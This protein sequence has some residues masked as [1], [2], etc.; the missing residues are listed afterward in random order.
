IGKVGSH[1]RPFALALNH[2]GEAAHEIAEK[3]AQIAPRL[4]GHHPMQTT[5]AQ[6]AAIADAQA[7]LHVALQDFPL[8]REYRRDHQYWTGV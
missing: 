5:V 4:M 6:V 7:K 3:P 2:G 8:E 1:D